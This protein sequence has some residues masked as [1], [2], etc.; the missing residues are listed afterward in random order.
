MRPL[1][2]RKINVVEMYIPKHFLT[3]DQPEMLAFM[4]EHNFATI[5]TAR[6]SLPPVATH[7]P[8]IIKTEGEDV[9]L[10]SHFARANPQWEDISDH[11]VLVI[12]NE[13]HAYIS[14]KH[15]DKVSNVPTW[16]Y[17]SVH[18]YG[19]GRLLLAEEESYEVLNGMIQDFEPEY[20]KQWD[21]LPAEF[22]SKMIRGIVAFEIRVT[23]LQGK[24][25]LSQN[26]TDEE[27]AR[28]VTALAASDNKNE[29]DIARYMK[30]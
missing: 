7:L 22:R 19:S 5:I 24:K 9:L 25:K 16:N 15:Y 29:R 27:R 4:R 10:I 8:F 30:T 2:K 23:G 14:P 20:Q 3:N 6:E 21:E 1:G 12:F 17:F 28:I 11:Q 18:A 26:R 13:P